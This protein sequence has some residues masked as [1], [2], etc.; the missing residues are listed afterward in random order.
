[1]RVFLASIA[2]IAVVALVGYW[3]PPARAADGTLTGKMIAFNYLIGGPWSCSITTPAM[4]GQPAHTSHATVTIDVVPS[5]VFDA[6][7]SAADDYSGDSYFGYSWNSNLY[8]IAT[9]DNTGAYRYATSTDGETYARISSPISSSIKDTHTYTK[10]NSNEVTVHEAL[11]D[12]EHQEII[13]TVCT[14]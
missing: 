8:W 14:R 9:A 7:E 4:D 2:A 5:N 6:H 1:M 12:G 3:S 13:D 10:V 11:S